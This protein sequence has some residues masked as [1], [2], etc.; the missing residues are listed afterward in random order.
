MIIKESQGQAQYQV[1]TSHVFDSVTSFQVNFFCPHPCSKN[2]G[3][4]KCDQASL[5]RILRSS[6][7]SFISFQERLAVPSFSP[8]FEDLAQFMKLLLLLL[9]SEVPSTLE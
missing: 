1:M 3:Q 2:V 9:L 4:E 7:C 6:S 5:S 8:S